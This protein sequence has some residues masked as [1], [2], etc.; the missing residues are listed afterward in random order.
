MF[1]MKL[2]IFWQIEDFL[3]LC[4][5]TNFVVLCWADLLKRFTPENTAGNL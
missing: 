3:P 1:F 2:N 5:D 4:E